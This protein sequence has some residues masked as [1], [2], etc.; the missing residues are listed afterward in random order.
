MD[1]RKHFIRATFAA[2]RRDTV[3]SIQTKALPAHEGA[4][5]GALRHAV[6]PGL[7]LGP[8]IERRLAPARRVALV[9]V[10]VDRGAAPVIGIDAGGEIALVE[11]VDVQRV[12]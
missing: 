10:A 11:A 4:E 1:G 8:A 12:F 2:L 5:I 3:L 9:G 7:V 6:L